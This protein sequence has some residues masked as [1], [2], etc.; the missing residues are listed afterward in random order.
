MS[1]LSLTKNYADSTLLFAADVHDMWSELETKTNGNLDNDNVTA[2]W[3]KFSQVTL[4]KD[5][6][7][8]LGASDS[9]YLYWKTSTSDMVFAFVTTQRDVLFKIANT[10]VMELDQD[11]NLSI[12]HDVYFHNKSTQYPL[13]SLIGYQ[14]PVL[15]YEDT[16]TV[17]VEQNTT[18]G[19]R[20]LIVFP[21]GPIS[22]TENTATSHKFRMLKLD[23]TAN[24]YSAAHTGAAD[25][26]LKSGLTLSSNTWYFVYA[27][28]VQGGDDASSDNFILVVDS[29]NPTPTNWSTL[30]TAYGS[31]MWVYIG[32]LRYGY[33]TTLEEELVPFVQDHSGWT[34]FTGRASTDNFFGIRLIEAELTSTS[35]GTILTL[36][37]GNSGNAVPANCSHYKM[38]YRPEA[39]GDE[40]NGYVAVYDSTDTLMWRMPSFAVNLTVDEAH[41]WEMKLPNVTSLKIKGA[42]G[43]P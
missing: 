29:T 13:S 8:T 11:S 24:G 39:S 21:S 35:I 31:G 17:Y 3:A 32:A 14:K 23:A 10:T 38:S 40:M 18:T 43:N 22:V 9:S 37:P 26:G 20:T 33:G 42:T 41:G 5:V 36:S 28:V 30:D 27:V 12:T 25:S 6:D 7:F 4:E 19:N 15:V 1:A 2:G 34:Y 16:N